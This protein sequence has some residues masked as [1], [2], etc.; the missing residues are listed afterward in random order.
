M[1][2]LFWRPGWV[3]SSPDEFQTSLRHALEQGAERGWVVDGNYLTSGGLAEEATT[4]IICQF[5]QLLTSM[6]A[7][8]IVVDDSRFHFSPRVGPASV[9]LFSADRGPHLPAPFQAQG[10]MQPRLRRTHLRNL[11]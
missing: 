5:F 4:D 8:T 2:E 7:P 10:V 9:C 11:L 6:P 1:D 3:K